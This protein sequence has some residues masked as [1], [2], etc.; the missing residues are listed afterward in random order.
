MIDKLNKKHLIFMF[1]PLLQNKLAR[2]KLICDN[3]F[4]L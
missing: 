2:T 3:P 1:I 4:K